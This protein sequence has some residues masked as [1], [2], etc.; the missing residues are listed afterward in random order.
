LAE[1]QIRV[2]KCFLV[3]TE[4]ELMKCL[5][6]EPEIF[7]KAIGRGKALK[8]SERVQQYERRRKGADD[9]G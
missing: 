2:N 1:L 5:A 7:R 3:L 8:R 9:I 4:S 6:R